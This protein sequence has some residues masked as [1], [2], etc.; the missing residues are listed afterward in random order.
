MLASD[1]VLEF[2]ILLTRSL[3]AL[4]QPPGPNALGARRLRAPSG[5]ARRRDDARGSYAGH[6]APGL[7]R[8]KG[9]SATSTRASTEYPRRSRGAAA[10]R[11]RSCSRAQLRG[12]ARPGRGAARCGRRVSFKGV[13]VALERRLR[14][15]IS[16]SAHE[17]YCS[18]VQL[19]Q[20]GWGLASSCRS[21][22]SLQRL[23]RP[24]A[25]PAFLPAG[26]LGSTPC[27]TGRAGSASGS[28]PLQD[29]GGG[30][31]RAQATRGK[32]TKLNSPRPGR[33]DASVV[34]EGAGGP[35]W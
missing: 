34:R 32:L 2:L 11:P 21:S 28:E 18:S 13:D 20:E 26:V 10:N 24:P 31:A 6:V 35:G 14:E 27:N 30:Q 17:A 5:R 19:V 15:E 33:P 3:G 12:A 25:L 22:S 7:P 4:R 8:P 23:R 9:S 1:R 16:R 29:R